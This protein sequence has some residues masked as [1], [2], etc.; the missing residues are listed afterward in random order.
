MLPIYHLRFHLVID[1][2]VPPHGLLVILELELDLLRCHHLCSFAKV[3]VS[4]GTVFAIPELVLHE[5]GLLLLKMEILHR[6]IVLPDS[7]LVCLILTY[8][9]SMGLLDALSLRVSLHARCTSVLDHLR[10]LDLLVEYVDSLLIVIL[11]VCQISDLGYNLNSALLVLLDQ[12]R[13]LLL[14]G[15][16]VADLELVVASLVL[17]NLVPNGLQRGVQVRQLLSRGHLLGLLCRSMLLLLR[18]LLL[19]SLL[20]DLDLLLNHLL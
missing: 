7:A 20:L 15:I 16:L 12:W 14:L 4:V 6:L 8:S 19:S 2:D 3:I 18:L 17:L 13:V 10:S 5:E 9:S 11:H 1:A